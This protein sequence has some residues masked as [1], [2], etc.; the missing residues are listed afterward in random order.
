MS[1]KDEGWYFRTEGAISTSLAVALMLWGL[2]AILL[3]SLGVL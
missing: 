1:K 2:V 3:V